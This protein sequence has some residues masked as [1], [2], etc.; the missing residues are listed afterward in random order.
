MVAAEEKKWEFEVYREAGE[1]RTNKDCTR[2]S[3]EDVQVKW[4]RM[5]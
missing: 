2:F 3:V 4:P 1:I 5:R